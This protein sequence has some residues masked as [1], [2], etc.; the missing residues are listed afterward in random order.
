M[1]AEEVVS[2]AARDWKIG[3][4]DVFKK[5]FVGVGENIQQVEILV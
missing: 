3:S 4:P 1:F 2:F 5:F